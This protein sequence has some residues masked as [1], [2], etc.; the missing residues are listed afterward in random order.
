VSSPS[1]VVVSPVKDEERYVE[2]TLRSMAAQTVRPARWVIVDD[3]STDRTLDIVRQWAEREPFIQPVRHPH[4]GP[5]Q[6]GSA[7]IRAFRHGYALVADQPHDIVVKLDCDLSF[8]VDY[9]E[10]LVGRFAADPTLGIASG[11]YLE[12]DRAGSWTRVSMPAY[13][14][15]GASKVVRRECY[16]RI[17]GFV[18]A[19]GWDT[20]DEIRALA[21]GW[22]TGHFAD[23]EIR[24][25]KREGAGIGQLRTSRMHGEIYYLTGGDPL[26]FVFKVLHRL[27]ERPVGL[28]A[29]A[30]AAGYLSAAVARERRLVTPLEARAYRRLLRQRLLRL[31][32]GAAELKPVQSGR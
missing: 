24:H 20:V 29:M 32:H 2:H 19:P 28:N 17:G 11:V 14:A 9:F 1:Y 27:A 6:P 5:R 15:C 3:G 7:V 12:K 13:H 10:R 23:L 30:L 21:H 25:H 26:F 8:E 16:D 18:A 22:S 4:S 31:G